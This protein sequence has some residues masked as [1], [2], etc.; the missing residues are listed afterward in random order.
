LFLSD[1]HSLADCQTIELQ[2]IQKYAIKLNATT[3]K[4]NIKKI[5]RPFQMVMESSPI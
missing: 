4:K 1:R 5:F 3:A 2:T